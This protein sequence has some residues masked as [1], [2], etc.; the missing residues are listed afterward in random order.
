MIQPKAP[1]FPKTITSHGIDRIDSYYWMRDRNHPD[2]LTYLKAENEYTEWMLQDYQDVREELYQEMRGRIKEKDESAPYFKHGYWYY[3]QYEDGAEHPIYCR[4]KESM[5]ATEEI[6][7]NENELAQEHSYY[8]IVSFSVSRDNRILAFCEDVTGRRLYRLRFKNLETG[9]FVGPV[10]EN[11]S[12]DLAWKNNNTELYFVRKEADTLRPYQA[13]LVN[14]QTQESSVVY[15]EEDDTYV[16]SVSRSKDFST[17]WMA[18]YSTDET[19]HQYKSAW[20]D[21]DFQHLL[22]RQEKHEYYPEILE[23][24]LYIKSN[25]GAENFKLYTAPLGAPLS[26]WKTFQEGSEDVMLEDFE[27]F[28]DF[29]V[30]QEKENGLSRL[31]IYDFSTNTSQVVP[32]EEETYTLYIGNNPECISSEVRIGYS[33]MTTPTSV[34]SM[35]MK[36]YEQTVLKQTEVLGNFDKE[37][38]QSERIW[39]E[40]ADGEK[41]AISL[42]YHKDHFQKNNSNP[43]LLYAY[44]S[45]GSTI[46]PYF[47]SVRLSLLDRGFVFAIAHIRGSEY[48]GRRWYEDGKLLKKKNTFSDYIQCAEHLISEGY[49]DSKKVFGMGGSAGGLLM[50]AVTNMRPDLWAGIVSQVPFVDVINT[51]EDES[52]PLTTGEYSEWGNPNDKEYWDYIYSYSPYDQIEAKDYPPMLI[53]SGLHDSQVQY[54]EPT[55]YVAKLRALKTN[56][57]PLLLHTNM[58]AGH[59]G[60]SGRFEQFKEIALNYAFIISLLEKNN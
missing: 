3:T 60:A 20:G 53:I 30:V 37:N 58:E 2:L 6:L 54:W 11:C 45:Y 26:E 36:T 32:M 50:G 49:C 43:V 5:K 22:K 55:K 8:E 21:E 46:D 18:S 23:G 31:R 33:S 1:L 47:S 34:I 13:Y 15:E 19:E 9:A 42:V 56:D 35:D 12:S 10:L 25:L 57:E 51:M 24:Q 7:L 4:R 28:R 48:L 41:I 59:G 17:I 29:L 52:I 14:Y 39:A 38:Y 27:A 16:L 44:G 40:A